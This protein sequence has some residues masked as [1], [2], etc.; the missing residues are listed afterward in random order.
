M[1]GGFQQEA[2]SVILRC[3]HPGIRAQ[4][5]SETL[6][7]LFTTVGV[8]LEF[9]PSNFRLPLRL[10]SVSTIYSKRCRLYLYITHYLRIL[11][12]KFYVVPNLI[13]LSLTWLIL[14]HITCYSTFTKL[15]LSLCLTK[16]HAM[17]TYWGSGGKFQAL[18]DIGT[19][20]RWVV[21]FKSPA[22]LLP[23]KEPHAG[24]YWAPGLVWTRCR[25]EKFP[26]P[27]EIRA[28]SFD[29]SNVLPVVNRLYRLSYSGS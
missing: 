7:T 8:W 6:K 23:V 24:T 22:A 29:H 16:H 18:F 19:I 12:A 21:S 13:F 10:P 25:R 26:G 11:T 20:R 14:V 3:Y 4:R 27:A 5:I 1:E 15:K 17:K 28:S 9:E 2:V